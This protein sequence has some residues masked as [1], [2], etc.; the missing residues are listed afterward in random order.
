MPLSSVLAMQKGTLGVV[1]VC[2]VFLLIAFFIGFKKG[3]RR[4]SWSGCIWLITGVVYFLL[5][6]W[7]GKT[8]ESWLQPVVSNF[9]AEESVAAFAASF[10]LAIVCILLALLLY[11]LFSLAFR[12]KTKW[13]E[14][15]GV[16]KK[17]K[18]GVEYDDECEDYDDYEKY[19]SRKVLV[20]TGYAKP[21]IFGRFV[22]GFICMLNTAAILIVVLSVA[23][24]AIDATPLKDGVLSFL[25]D[26]PAF[27][28]ALQY[29]SDFTLDWLFIGIIFAIAC[30]GNKNG[31]LETFRM[32]FVVFGTL[33]VLALSFWLPFSPF[34][35]A[36]EEGGDY[37]L[38]AF[39]TRCTTML[40]TFG[41]A[42][43]ICLIAGRVV[44]GILLAVTFLLLL[45][46][47]NWILKKGVE[48]VER[49]GFLR[50]LD[51]A[52]SSMIYLV[53]GVAVVALIGA[54]WC[55][56]AHYGL[57]YAT[58]LFGEGSSLSSGLYNVYEIYLEPYLVQ[59]DEW[60]RELVASTAG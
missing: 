1:M 47:V 7:L 49:V 58:E 31:L 14:R 27:T 57:F 48:L 30:K 20:R 44:A 46:L 59:L 22:G 17:D 54:V 41:L 9:T 21:S 53:V 52:L 5:H 34:A 28:T 19:R 45:A 42:E 50:A 24:L 29:A 32:L 43:N 40:E 16:Y 25:Y 38:N 2:A 4:V 39:V 3:G 56:F 13:K 12:P 15:E 23:L 26:S 60:V 36:V 6:R 55:V 33:A 11:G 35:N 8:I 37:F 51:G 10:A 18:N